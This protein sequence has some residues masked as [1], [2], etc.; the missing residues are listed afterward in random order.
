MKPAIFLLQYTELFLCTYITLLI[1][2]KI[3]HC[4]GLANLLMFVLYPKNFCCSKEYY[5]EDFVGKYLSIVHIF[6][7]FVGVNSME[8][9]Y[10]YKG[11]HGL[12]LWCIL[13]K[14]IQEIGYLI[15]QAFFFIK[16]CKYMCDCI[17]KTCK[18]KPILYIKCSCL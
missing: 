17:V 16:L 10:W 4:M 7:Y 6:D 9:Y 8:W 2:N 5:N 12:K 13:Q 18:L 3:C 1:M 14:G 11:I 15:S